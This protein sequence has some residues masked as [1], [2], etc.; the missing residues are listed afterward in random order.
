MRREATAQAALA[1]V[2][3]LALSGCAPGDYFDKWFGSG[4]AMKPAELVAFKPTASTRILW[5]GSVG[6]ARQYVFTPLVDAGAVYAAGASGQIVRFD[7]TSGKVLARIDTRN[8]LAGGVGGNH[9]L[10]LLGNAK[11]EVLALDSGGKDL[12]KAQLTS[13]VLSAPQV[14]QGVV[15]VRTGNGRIYGLDAATG[16]HKWVYQRLLPP[17]TV[18]TFIGVVLHRGAVFAGFPGGRMVAIA[19]DSGNVG[20]EATVALPRPITTASPAWAWTGLSSSHT[21][22]WCSAW[23]E[24][25]QRSVT[26]MTGKLIA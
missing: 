26:P 4:P 24:T 20:W 6:A 14:D 7:A 15:V 23:V 21:A 22:V 18:R 11:G 3:A 2:L 12:W 19:L 8:S 5:H 10:L 9:N 17:L 13:E 25:C 1:A 16:T